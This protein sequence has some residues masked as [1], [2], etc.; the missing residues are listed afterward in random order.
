MNTHRIGKDMLASGLMLGILWFAASGCA[1]APRWRTIP[2]AESR[3]TAA[4]PRP[5]A[6]LDRLLA[7]AA[8]RAAA[9]DPH[10]RVVPG[11]VWATVI[12]CRDPRDPRMGSLRGTQPV[13][14][15]SVVKLCYMLAAY[16]QHAR[17]L[18][19]LDSALR[20]DLKLMIGP[21]DNAATNR[22]LDRLT[23]TAFGPELD[24]AAWDSFSHKRMTVVR[25]LRE[26]GLG[27][28]NATNKTFQP[29]AIPLFGRDVQW[30]GPPRDDHFTH[31]N[32]MTTDDTAR[33][34]YL[35]ARRAVVDPAAC[36]DM[37]EL[38]RRKPDPESPWFPSAVPPGAT[39]Y[40]KDGLTS[41]ELHDA[42]IFDLGGDKSIILVIFTVRRGGPASPLPRVVPRMAK[43]VLDALLERPAILDEPT[44]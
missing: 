12:D 17:G 44:S 38:M 2:L 31:S 4:E 13:Y 19:D 24:G 22:I 37:L 11:E 28:L 6:A 10:A 1:T 14:P 34:L 30:L 9:E 18:L 3:L 5:S 7:E 20:R 8:A 39:L 25:Y 41:L 29:P 16:D 43:A 27:G 26:L 21:S 33:L 35:L 36:D 42:G 23:N 15:A 32:S 40:S